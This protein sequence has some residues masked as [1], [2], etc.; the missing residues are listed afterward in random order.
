MIKRLAFAAL[1]VFLGTAFLW[2]CGPFLP[3]WLL[4]PEDLVLE[5]PRV[6]F[7]E[8]IR[9][10]APASTLR[11]VE[12]GDAPADQTAQA[13]VADLERAVGDPAVV[14]R[15]RT[16][17]EAL[18]THGGSPETLAGVAVPPGLPGEFADYLEGAIAW[19]QGRF[20]EAAAAWERLLRRPAA[21][22][23]QR[24][25]WA[26]FMLGKVHLRENREQAARWFQR[27]RE[28][29]GEGF[30]DSLGLAASSLGWEA[31][32]ER[33]R[34][35]FDRAIDLY[36][37]QLGTG[38]PT[39]VSSIR[40]TGR[41]ALTA[42]QDALVAIAR[43]PEARAALTVFVIA[44]PGEEAPWD[45]SGNDL[46]AKA[47][48][49]A[50]EAAGVR[51]IPEADRIAWA[52]YLAG[53]FDAAARWLERAPQEAPMA[54]WIKARLLL[55]AGKLAE[56]QALLARV[57]GEA[58]PIQPDEDQFFWLGWETGTV[59]ATP[60]RAAGE[61]AAVRLARG[62]LVPALDRFLAGGYWL[63][64]SY[65]A[66]RVLTLDELRRAVDGGWPA[67]LAQRHEHEESEWLL[68]GGYGP[69]DRAA[70]AYHLRYLLGRRL[71]RE[72]R[73]QEAAPYLPAALLPR[74]EAL[75]SALALG[76]DAARSP[77]ERSQSLFRAAC[78]TRQSGMRLLGTEAEPD[79]TVV[80]GNYDLGAYAGEKMR[81]EGKLAPGADE[82]ER[83]RRHRAQPWKRFHYRYRAADLAWDAAQL[84]PDGGEEKAEIL[85]TGGNWIGKQDPA[86]ADRFY[87]ALVR[88][89]GTTELGRAA[90][91]RRWLP[92][93][94]SCPAESANRV[95]R[96]VDELDAPS[97]SSAGG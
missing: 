37:Q 65:V 40:L 46:D 62:E 6:L 97:G 64:S 61:E 79:W 57:A 96:E 10:L 74:L 82:K 56:A 35:R 8:E 68:Y 13:D 66:E 52:A 55:R 50:V 58:P 38:D 18:R 48:L 71:A 75:T 92:P 22:R 73:Y 16:V 33:D 59:L 19:H 29:A 67:D 20:P 45:E 70:L 14:A 11:A 81:E 43:D 25:T 34:G 24:S 63:D 51:D 89:C 91:E 5:G 32:A 7:S 4:G 54:H 39:A 85:A 3:N 30:A 21:E 95:T 94:D 12:S 31:R 90:A 23:R 1:A 17:R 44:R 86:A 41:A 93:A 42:G 80:E 69:P 36:V 72:G 28:L 47:W 78:L 77:Q 26:A 49:A 9:K 84:L 15:Y 60:T 53:D 27:T 87:K 88:C 76:Q 83:E 2:A